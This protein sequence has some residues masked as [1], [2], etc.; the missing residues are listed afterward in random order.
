MRN[1]NK[2]QKHLFVNSLF[3]TDST[4]FFV[5]DFSATSSP[6][7]ASQG[8]GKLQLG[9]VH[10]ALSVSLL[11]SHAAPLLQCVIPLTGQSPS[12]TAPVSPS[13]NAA[14]FQEVIS[15]LLSVRVLM[16]LTPHESVTQ[17]V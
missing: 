17:G 5:L 11:P 16:L 7:Q 1:R 14:P 10:N 6:P 4:P 15:C 13:Q 12:Q 8:D 3:F 9:S 2:K